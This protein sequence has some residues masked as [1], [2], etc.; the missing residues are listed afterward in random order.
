MDQ[1]SSAVAMIW[2]GQCQLPDTARL[3]LTLPR[4]F[5]RRANDQTSY[6]KDGVLYAFNRRP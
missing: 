2:P 4:H 6:L 3:H 1:R 5:E